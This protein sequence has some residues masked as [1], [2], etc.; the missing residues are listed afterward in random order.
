M[1]ETLKLR[2]KTIDKEARGASTVAEMMRDRHMI[3]PQTPVDLPLFY[4]RYEI[5]CR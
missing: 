2:N 5:V 1:K 3:T 4:P